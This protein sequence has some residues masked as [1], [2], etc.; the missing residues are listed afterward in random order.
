MFDRLALSAFS[1]S[2]FCRV[3][4]SNIFLI[5]TCREDIS[6]E[7]TTVH[8]NRIARTHSMVPLVV[9]WY[10]GLEPYHGRRAHTKVPSS[11][12]DKE[13]APHLAQ[14]HGAE[15]AFVRASPPTVQRG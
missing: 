11:R 15:K 13:L 6:S 4:V 14:K 7:K 1:K 9:W 10:E 3:E 8:L 2:V 5:Y 12:H